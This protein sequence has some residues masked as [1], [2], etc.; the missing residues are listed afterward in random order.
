MV[1]GRWT[2]PVPESRRVLQFLSVAVPGIPADVANTGPVPVGV[3]QSCELIVL[4]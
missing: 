1:L 4:G 2:S 3:S